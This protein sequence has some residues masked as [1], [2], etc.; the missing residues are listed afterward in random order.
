MA[1][2]YPYASAGSLAKAI[3]QFKKSFPQTV[4]A[5]TLKKFAIAPNNESYVISVLRFLGFIDDEG[6]RVDDNVSFFYGDRTTLQSGLESALRT[7]Y[8]ALFDDFGDEIWDK[9]RSELVPWFRATD[10]S[11]ETVGTRQATTF[12]ALAGLAG[13]GEPPTPSGGNGTTS[14]PADSKVAEKKP[15]KPEAKKPGSSPASNTLA[16]GTAASVVGVQTD[17]GLTVRI[18]VNLPPTGDQ[19]TYDAIFRSIRKNLIEGNGA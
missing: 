18:E 7:A 15:K 12:V 2:S 3:E 9:T 8:K 13:H 5:T 6:N 14:M 19:E 10:K 4:T 17:I 11:S 16:N 1:T